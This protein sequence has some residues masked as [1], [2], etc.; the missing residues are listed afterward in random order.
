M[1]VALGNIKFTCNKCGWSK[2]I[3]LKSDVVY[4]EPSKC[5]KCGGKD[6][7]IEKTGSLANRLLEF[8]K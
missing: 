4:G 7:K 3:H 6:F 8:F 1:V 2:S 5:P